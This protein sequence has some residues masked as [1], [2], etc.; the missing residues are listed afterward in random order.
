M[1]KSLNEEDSSLGIYTKD[2]YLFIF[3]TTIFHILVRIFA[4]HSREEPC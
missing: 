2:F 3:L 4:V 1:L